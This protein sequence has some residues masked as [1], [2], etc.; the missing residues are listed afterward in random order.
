[1]ASN[2]PSPQNRALPSGCVELCA[3]FIG[4]LAKTHL[5][6]K[7]ND[8]STY[9]GVVYFACIFFGGIIIYKTLFVLIGIIV[10]KL[11]SRCGEGT[12]GR[13]TSKNSK[14]V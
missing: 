9:A 3:W 10:D 8:M 1:M 11:K 5:W 14:D 6:T 4:C 13:V 12:E 2:S 7:T